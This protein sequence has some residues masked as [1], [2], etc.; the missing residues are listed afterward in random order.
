MAKRVQ[1]AGPA[2]SSPTTPATPR[3]LWRDGSSGAELRRRLEALPG[4]GKQKAQIFV[5]LLGKQRGVRPD[6]WREAAGGYG[7]DGVRRSVAD[8]TDE[9]DARGGPG[10][11]E[12]AE[13]RQG[14]TARPSGRRLGSATQ[15]E[16]TLPCSSTRSASESSNQ[17]PFAPR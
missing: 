17:C 4:Y 14:L 13:G 5:A 10:V 16:T 8:V 9:P 1:D 11:Q 12:A 3:A 15:A 7:E 2:R 6:G